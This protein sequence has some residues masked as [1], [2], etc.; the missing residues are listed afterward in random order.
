MP[1]ATKPR[2][3]DDQPL[4]VGEIT[5][6]IAAL[7]GE[8]FPRAAVRGQISNLRRQSSGHVYFTLKDAEAQLPAVMWRSTADRL[9][10]RPE[11]GQD[12]VAM[13]KIDVYPPHGKY[14]LV[15]TGLT[16]L[17]VGDL[18]VRFEQLKAQLASE[19]LFDEERKRPL[20]LVPRHVAV[21]TSPTGAAVRDLLKIALRR[22][23]RAWITVIPARV[24]GEGSIDDVVAAIRDAAKLPDV[25]VLIVGRGGGSIEDLW[26]FNE[27]AVARAIAAAPMP[28]VSAVGHETDTTIADFVADLRA[29]TPSESA[30]IVFPDVAELL[31]RIDENRTRLSRSVT[32]RLELARERLVALERTHALAQPIERLRRLAQDLDEWETRSFA[33]LERHVHRSRERLSRVAGHLE[34]VSPLA[35]L[36][37]GYSITTRDGHRETLRGIDGLGPG[38]RL[39]TRLARGTVVSEVVEVHPPGV[40]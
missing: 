5:T 12:V 13:G 24:Q 26:T 34:A 35:V 17:G 28:V 23:P 30:E 25:D 10:F 27:E 21:V 9:R 37:R 3:P 15:C 2:R 18:H 19:G 7:L 14:Q 36:A 32:H 11:D 29:A 16:P 20:P 40:L 8:A 39:T 1:A 22:M 31:G 33:A 4:T 6:V 38:E